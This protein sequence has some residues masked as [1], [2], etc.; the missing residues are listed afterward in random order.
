MLLYPFKEQL[1]LSSL[2]VQPVTA[3]EIDGVPVVIIAV[4]TLPRFECVY[5]RHN[6]CKYSFPLFI[7]RRIGCLYLLAKN[8]GF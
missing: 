8:Y 1:N 7:V 3:S 4:N 6:L 5:K 2:L